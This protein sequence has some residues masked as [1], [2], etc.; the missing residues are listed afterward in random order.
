[1]TQA[2]NSAECTAF[3]TNNIPREAKTEIGAKNQNSTASGV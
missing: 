3:F 1:M 2:S